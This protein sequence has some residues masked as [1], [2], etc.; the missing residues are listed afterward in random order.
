MST[1]VTGGGEGFTCHCHLSL[2]LA[3]GV[4]LHRDH[5]KVKFLPLSRWKGSLTQEDIPYPFIKLGDTDHLDFIGVEI[6]A[7][8]WKPGE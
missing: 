6:G 2:E 4:C 7:H 1:G 5:D 8:L 3:A